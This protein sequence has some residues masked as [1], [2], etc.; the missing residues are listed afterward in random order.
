MSDR[1]LRRDPAYAQAEAAARAII[2]KGRAALTPSLEEEPMKR[3]CPAPPQPT[4]RPPAE[5][6]I[7]GSLD[8]VLESL[9]EQ[10]QLLVDLLGSVNALT[11]AVLS[12]QGRL[13]H[14]TTS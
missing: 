13:G 12:I 8:R 9:A 10:N 7:R 14:L 5:D 1:D 2:A 6:D 11:A 3:Y 4:C